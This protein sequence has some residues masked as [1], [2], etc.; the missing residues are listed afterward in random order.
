V[1]RPSYVRRSIMFGSFVTD[2][3]CRDYPPHLFLQGWL[4]VIHG[5]SIEYPSLLVKI[6]TILKAPVSTV[7]MRQNGAEGGV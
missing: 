5:Y 6:Y 4:I 2:D 7:V 3:G 1:T